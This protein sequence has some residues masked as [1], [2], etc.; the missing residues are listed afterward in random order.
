MEDIDKQQSLLLSGFGEV[1]YRRIINNL[2]DKFKAE[3]T[4]LAE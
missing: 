4:S 2:V 3:R 1:T